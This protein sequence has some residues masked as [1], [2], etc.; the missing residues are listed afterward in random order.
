MLWLAIGALVLSFI[1]NIALISRWSGRVEQTQKSHTEILDRHEL[2]HDFHY[3][4]SREH[5]TADQRHFADTD[6]HWNRREREWLNTRFE[7]V[8]ERFDKIER[9]IA[10]VRAKS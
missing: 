6:M 7:E 10:A 3:K 2:A 1:V 8:G 4:Q 9:M 5:E